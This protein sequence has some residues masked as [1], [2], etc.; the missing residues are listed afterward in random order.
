MPL[1]TCTVSMGQNNGHSRQLFGKFEVLIIFITSIPCSQRRTSIF[2]GIASFLAAICV[3]RVVLPILRKNVIQK[4]QIYFNLSQ[5][6]F[7]KP[8]RI[9]VLQIESRNL[10]FHNI[11]CTLCYCKNLVW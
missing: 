2:G 3:R 5:S 10:L 6:K 4:N 1:I 8:G 11:T 9:T 7:L